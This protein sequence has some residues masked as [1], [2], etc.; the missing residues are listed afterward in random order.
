MGGIA[1]GVLGAG[2]GLYNSIKGAREARDAE[3]ALNNYQRQELTNA[4]DGLTVSR[5]GAD[6]QRADQAQLAATQV[7]ALRGAGTRG[8]IGGIGAV[9]RNNMAVADNI[10][11]GLDGQQKEI[12]QFV[13][14]DEQRIRQ[15]Q[16]S[17]ENADLA[18]LSSQLQAGKSQHQMGMGNI[19]QGVG[20]IAGGLGAAGVFG[21]ERQ[22]VGN[23]YTT[24][25]GFGMA[26]ADRSVM[27]PAS[28]QFSD[29]LERGYANGPIVTNA[30]YNAPYTTPNFNVPNNPQFGFGPNAYGMFAGPRI[31][32]TRY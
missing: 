29:S 2:M 20:G 14:Q 21:G 22:A 13:A 16:E 32:Q 26:P 17:R 31:P 12:D 28:G 18:A 1:S 15:M 30:G 4:G 19:I 3:N 25:G 11:A 7:D 5:L 8:M 9:G 27:S 23:P 6:V 24:T 10:A